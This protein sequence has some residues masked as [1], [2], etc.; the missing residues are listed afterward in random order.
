MARA[1]ALGIRVVP[2]VGP[3][4]IVLA[5][6]ASGMNGQRFSFLG[7]LPQGQE[8]LRERL[9]EVQREAQRGITQVFIETP[10]RNERL[11]EAIA[12]TCAPTLR[13]CTASGLTGADEAII[14][15]TIAQWRALLARGGG[16]KL[17]RRP[18]VFLLMG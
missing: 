4:S 3:S 2:W 7:Y 16:P 12:R 5:L 10:Y 6:M 17:D 15:Q 11:L 14:V 18:T 1:H 9:L 13:L 8:P